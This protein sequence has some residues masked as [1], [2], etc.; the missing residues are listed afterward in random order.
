MPVQMSFDSTPPTPGKRLF[1]MEVPGRLPSWNEI[2]GMEQWARYKYKKDLANVFLCELRRLESACSTKT[3]SAKNIWSIYAATLASSLETRQRQRILRSA[4]KRRSRAV[5]ST[6]ASK[7][8][9]SEAVP[10]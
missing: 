3:T 10:F 8:L 4:S 7:S 5:R 6:A 9:K 1:V 2:L